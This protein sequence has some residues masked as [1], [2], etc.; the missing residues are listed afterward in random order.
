MTLGASAWR[1]CA[2]EG[3]P[4]I[5]CYQRHGLM[6][7]HVHIVTPIRAFV[8]LHLLLLLS[9]YPT[10]VLQSFFT[11]REWYLMPSRMDVIEGTCKHGRT[12]NP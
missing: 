9:I 8:A 11:R 5:S 4:L 12:T 3:G 2:G 6:H 7:V 10:L 1:I